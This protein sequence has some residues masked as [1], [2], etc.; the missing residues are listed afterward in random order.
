M[1]MASYAF[2]FDNF[3]STNGLGPYPGG[4]KSTVP[5]K[6]AFVTS[7][8]MQSDCWEGWEGTQSL[9]IWTG[10]KDITYIPWKSKCMYIGTTPDNIFFGRTSEVYIFT[11]NHQPDRL[12][13]QE[14]LHIHELLGG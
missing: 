14:T 10:P 12:I 5:A 8:Q 7:S 2:T 1:K 9:R 3:S 11:L 4:S 13:G 6:M